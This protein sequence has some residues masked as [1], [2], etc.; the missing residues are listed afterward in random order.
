M[1]KMTRVLNKCVLWSRNKDGSVSL[2]SG[3]IFASKQDMLEVVKD[4]CI[5]DGFHL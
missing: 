5:Q 1:N 3:H 2:V 4:F